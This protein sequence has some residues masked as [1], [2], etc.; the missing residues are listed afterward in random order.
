MLS[1][2]LYTVG[3]SGA[4]P[5]GVAGA[6]EWRRRGRDER[7][8]RQYQGAERVGSG[9]PLHNGGGGCAPPQKFFRSVSSKRRV[10][11]HSGT[12]KTYF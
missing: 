6:S 10:L 1:L 11:V 7:R 4:D 9:C 5:E 3:E 12:D 8:R 2:F